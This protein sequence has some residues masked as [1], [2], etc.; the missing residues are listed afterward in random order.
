[1]TRFEISHEQ[2]FGAVTKQ[3]LVVLSHTVWRRVKLADHL[4]TGA[5]WLR[6]IIA[7]E[8]GVLRS[9]EQGLEVRDRLE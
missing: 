7:P 6:S 9:I 5:A 4:G 8:E 2:I 1:M 3:A